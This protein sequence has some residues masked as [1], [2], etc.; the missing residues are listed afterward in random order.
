M[1][2]YEVSE[3]DSTQSSIQIENRQFVSI[4]KKVDQLIKSEHLDTIPIKPWTIYSTQEN[5][6][7]RLFAQLRFQ[8]SEKLQKFI[9]VANNIKGVYGHISSTKSV[10]KNQYNDELYRRLMKKA[11]EEANSIAK[12]ADKRLGQIMQV[13]ER[14]P[15]VGGRW[16]AYPPMGPLGMEDMF[17]PAYSILIHK[18]FAVRFAWHVE[19]DRSIFY[20]LH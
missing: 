1:P 20:H 5:A 2:W 3:N 18:K 6:R 10:N 4:A 19:Y 8:S 11:K 9:A 13:E 17:A 16:V 15:N 14:D 12:N 7:G